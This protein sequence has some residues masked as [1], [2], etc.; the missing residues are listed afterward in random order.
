MKKSCFV[1]I[2]LIIS[3]LMVACNTEKFEIKFV[4]W[5]DT[6]IETF[7][8]EKGKKISAPSDPTRV[9]YE[10]VNWDTSF[11]KAIENLIIKAVYI[12][13]EFT[14]T[15]KNT[16]GSVLKEEIVTYGKPATAPRVG[17]LST[18]KFV[19]WDKDFSNVTED[20]V[21][22]TVYKSSF[23]VKFI[24]LNE[25]VLKEETVLYGKN[26]TAPLV[27]NT[28]TLFFSKW[29]KEFSVVKDDLEVRAIFTDN[30]FKL[31]FYDGNTLLNLNVDS[32]RVGDD[33]ILPTPTKEGYEFVGWFLSD[34][35][36]FEV[37]RI[38]DNLY[39]DIKLYASWFKTTSDT[40][41]VPDNGIEIKNI[42]K[43]AHS[44]GVGFVYQPEMPSGYSATAFDWT[45]SNTKIATISIYSSISVVSP[46]Y[47]IISGVNKT[48]PSLIVY[49]I[50]ETSSDG[51]TRT[52]LEIA[53]APNY[54]YATFDFEDGTKIRKITSKG[55]FVVAPTP[56]EKAG[57]AF[58]GWYG[59]DGEAT[60]DIK[61]DTT[62]KATYVL[63]NNKYAGKTVSFLGDSITT[64]EGYI[65]TGYAKFYPYATGDVTDVNH[66]WWMQVVNKLGMKLLAN[67]SW[68]GSAVAGTQA[69]ATQNV[70]RLKTM[71]VDGVTPDVIVIFM[72]NN[73]AASIYISEKEFDEAYGKMLKNIKTMAP[74]SEIIILNL[75]SIK[76][77]DEA[78]Q[79]TFNQMIEK[80]ANN[81]EL[82]IIKLSEVFDRSTVSNYLMDSAHPN[83]AGMNLIANKVLDNLMNK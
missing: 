7:Y 24:G 14:V 71:F 74:N 51:V 68:G 66:T 39:G 18:G 27:Q 30:R 55:G 20:L 61:K 17:D 43:V 12:E 62:F 67:N 15:F 44:S 73:D 31:E 8:I 58:T 48:N 38:N 21:V 2:M 3:F 46:G 82:Q 70:N 32:Y 72:G 37:N 33:F 78:K 28:D 19:G 63:G 22:T 13:K 45:S 49:C 79:N 50:I 81:N 59:P 69:S 26:A 4:D 47:A 75:P 64:Y 41:E 54:V 16:E 6:V 34:I 1:F 25:E 80:H 36:L 57:Y 23:T 56:K 9:G 52:T 5:D 76:L 11:D 10:F 35:S 77:F 83:R 65:P 60:F 42:K 40:F 29:D 53:Q